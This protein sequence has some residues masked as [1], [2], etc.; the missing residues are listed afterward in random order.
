MT[1]EE[2]RN[3]DKIHTAVWTYDLAAHN[4]LNDT[5][6]QSMTN[7]LQELLDII[8]NCKVPITQ[9]KMYSLFSQTTHNLEMLL[10]CAPLDGNGVSEYGGLNYFYADIAKALG[11]SVLYGEYALIDDFVN[12]DGSEG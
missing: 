2:I 10:N 4:K 12:I 1:L 9:Q 6:W 7:T 11:F 3:S 5:Q 8:I